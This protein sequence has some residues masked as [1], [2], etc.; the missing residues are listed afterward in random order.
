MAKG[1]IKPKADWRAVDSPKK[2]TNEFG[3]FAIKSK[4]AKKKQIR[5]I[6]NFYEYD[7][8]ILSEIYPSLHVTK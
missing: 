3:V 7:L 1:K 5:D 4:K 6:A 8:K 2:Q